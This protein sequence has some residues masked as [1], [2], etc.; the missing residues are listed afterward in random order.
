MTDK[1]FVLD[2]NA[3]TNKSVARDFTI[4]A[5]AGAFL[6]LDERTYLAA[7]ANFTT[8]K[9]DKVIDDHIAAEL[10]VGRDYAKLLEHESEGTGIKRAV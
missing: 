1:D 3:F 7:I 5:Y 8:V 4:A 2:R 9:V 6:N 10:N